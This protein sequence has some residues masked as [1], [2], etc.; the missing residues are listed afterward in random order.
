MIWLDII[1]PKYVM[2]FAS[3]IPQ[4]RTFDE[5]LVTT[6]KSE[7]YDECARLLTLFGIESKAIGGYGG[8]SKLG[9]F[10][11][12]LERQKAFI[13]LFENLGKLPR[14]FV[15]GAS[16][17]GVQCAF[18]LGIPI[19]HFADT[20]VADCA[21]SKEKL[22]VLSRLTLP[23]S[24]L[25]FRPFV[26]PEICYSGLGLSPS[27]ICAYHFID[28]VLW[29]D[30]VPTFEGR[31]SSK[32]ATFIE[33]FALDST[34]PIILVRE[35]E[36]KAHYVRQ[37]LPVIYESIPLLCEVANVLIMP[38]Y[39]SDELE[40]AFSRYKNVKILKTILEPKAFYPFIDVLV[41]GG[42]T[43]NLEACYLGIP[44]VSTRSLLLFHDKFLLD[45]KL[46]F[47]AQNAQEVISLC[48]KL[49]LESTQKAAHKRQD[50]LFAPNGVDLNAIF[51]RIKE[52][53]K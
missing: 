6:R 43:M 12:R 37:K 1:D 15:T 3:F 19:V 10:Q 52:L 48:E 22:T 17:D 40:S 35:E 13:A 53:L 4:L 16:V 38:R 33:Q 42:G 47:H 51:T 2:F 25:V 46:M 29:L 45:N 5:V 50:R 32:R 30:N 9:K 49:L 24:T 23:L 31:D 26:V 27:Q 20:P 36:Y 11:S 21:F 14:L 34:L 28:V 39:G 8:E 7:G 41:G 44:V 18:G